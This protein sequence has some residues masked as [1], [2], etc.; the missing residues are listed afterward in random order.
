MLSI[1]CLARLPDAPKGVKGISLFLSP[2]F[3]PDPDGSLGA[4]NGILVG[5]L[6]HKMEIHGQPTCVMNFDGATGWL[7][8]EPGRGLNAMFTMMNAERLFVG[9]QGLGIAEIANQNAAA[10]AKERRQG[11]SPAG[12]RTGRSPLSSTRT[13]AKCCSPAVPLPMRAGRWRSGR[14]CR[15]ILPARHPDAEAHRRDA[16]GLVSLM[17]PI[18]KAAFTDF[19]FGTR[20]PVAAGV[21]WSWLHT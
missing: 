2:K 6:E 18:I 12:A 1:W 4:R 21:W 7:V 14:P 20:R 8:G 17:T 19:G 16:D 11:R 10:Y 5:S 9:I 15:W 3:I 13:C